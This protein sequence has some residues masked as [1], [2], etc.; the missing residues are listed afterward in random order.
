MSANNLDA[1]LA[2]RSSPS[3]TQRRKFDDTPE[4][5]D[6]SPMMD[7]GPERDHT[8][9]EAGGLFHFAP[10]DQPLC[11]DD[12]VA[13]VYIDD[14]AAVAGCADCLDLVAEDLQDENDYRGHCL[15]CR[16]EITA[17][18]G[19]APD[20]PTALPALRTG[21]M[22]MYSNPAPQG[23]IRGLYGLRPFLRGAR[24]VD[25]QPCTGAQPIRSSKLT[26]G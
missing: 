24:P 4:G 5:F 7:Q 11:G 26:A 3:A 20:R 25:P 15:H 21:G 14:P 23:A 8:P 6:P 10:G 12:C 19:V 22:V 2:T 17:R 18:G 9:D 13:R 16:R 1:L